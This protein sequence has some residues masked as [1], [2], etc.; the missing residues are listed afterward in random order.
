M[1]SCTPQRVAQRCHCMSAAPTRSS[2]SWLSVWHTAW[3]VPPAA[4]PPQLL[5]AHNARADSWRGMC[6]AACLL[7][8]VPAGWP[9]C[10]RTPQMLWPGAGAADADPLVAPA[11]FFLLP[12]VLGA[13][14]L[15]CGPDAQAAVGCQCRQH[16]DQGWPL[17]VL[18]C[19]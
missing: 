7:L 2:S 11:A 1:M 8:A 15:C 4:S 16:T 3:C 13:G 12:S 19:G 9:A 17:R 5:P 6:A 10:L 14:L 18:T